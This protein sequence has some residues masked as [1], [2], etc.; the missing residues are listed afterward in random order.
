MRILVVNGHPD[1]S[2]DRF[3]APIATAY[4]EGARGAGHAVEVLAAGAIAVDFLT[5]AA[6]FATP[7]E[8]AIAEA[9]ARIRVADHLV[10]VYP[11]WLGTMPARLKAFLEQVGRGEFFIGPAE[12]GH[13]WPAKKLRGKSARLIVTMGMPA[14]AYRLFFGA[15]GVKAV[16]SAIL[17]LA[18]FHPVHETLFG[19]VDASAERRASILGKARRLG[20]EGR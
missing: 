13:R 9:Q 19:N 8:G 14:M 1:P 7:A 3:A 5:G 11:L 17:G 10:L 15:H 2:P 4:A 12:P 16:E 18:G 20:A 6:A